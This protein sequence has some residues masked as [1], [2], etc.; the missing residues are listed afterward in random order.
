MVVCITMFLMSQYRQIFTSTLLGGLVASFIVLFLFVSCQSHPI[1]VIP[2]GSH[3]LTGVLLPVQISLSRRGTHALMQEGKEV[4][5][6]E[7]ST[8][9]LRQMEKVDV[10][11]VGHFE[12][13][14]DPEALPVLVASGV[15]LASVRM[16]TFDLSSFGLSL[17]VPPEWNSQYVQG[18]VRFSASGSSIFLAIST[19][20]LIPLPSTNRITVGG[21]PASL[22]SSSG[23]STLSIHNG[24][25]MIIFEFAES[26]P[27]GDALMMRIIRSVHFTTP[28][29]V[30]SSMSTGTGANI[31]PSDG[32]PC[33]GAAG[34]LCPSGSYCAVT[35]TVTNIGRCRSLKR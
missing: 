27:G 1:V 18:G 3:T 20:S 28:S 17:D 35:D 22:V 11:V 30:P 6:V 24:S 34:L 13:N 25:S 31:P 26:I 5:L 14:T 2:E 4:A 19:G 23:A 7:S 33:G 10:I 9:N 29:S 15:T 16:H 21:R 32:A 8:V 12:R